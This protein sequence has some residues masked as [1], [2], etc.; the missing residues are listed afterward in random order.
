[1]GRKI[2]W[3]FFIFIFFSS[4]LFAKTK[5]IVFHA[6]SLSV[7]FM[8][9]EKAF[10][11]EHPDVDVQR[12]IGGSRKLARMIVD[13]GKYADVYASAD[14]T[15]INEMLIPKYADKNFKFASNEMVICYTDKSKYA[16][17]INSKNWYKILLK[18]D[19]KY[20]HSNPNLDPCGYRTI[21]LLKLAEKYYKIPNFFKNIRKDKSKI[22]VR[23]KEVDLTPLLKEGFI[24][25]FFIYKSIA[26]QHHFKYVKLPDKINLSKLKYNKFYST[27][28]VKLT[29]KKPGEFV[30]KK[31]KAIIYG[32]TYLKKSKHLNLAKKF[33]K[34]VLDKNKGGKIIEECGQNFLK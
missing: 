27:V 30:Y 3:M 11:K 19:V 18:K 14:Y 25:Y 24:D 1:M 8:K 9:I 28:K 31:G 13:V 23:P 17:K 5:L 2:Q 32:I 29:G 6:G 22:I 33:I 26:V 21:L 15:L 4:S 20:G 16:D 10:E 7:P 34:F 12:V